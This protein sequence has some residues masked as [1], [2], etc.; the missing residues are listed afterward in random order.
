MLSQTTNRALMHLLDENRHFELNGRGTTN[1]CPMA[2]YALAAMGASDARL[3]EFFNGW[4]ERHAIA[5]GQGAIAATR[6]NYAHLM[7]NMPAFGGLRDCFETWIN[8]VG[9]TPIVSEV[10]QAISFAPAS[11]A[12]HALIRLAY[13]LEAGHAGEIA[14]GLAAMVCGHL[15]IE[16]ERGNRAPAASV[17]DGLAMLSRQVAG[18][19]IT[20]NSITSRLRMVAADPLFQSALPA[21]PAGLGLLDE[22]ALAALA[23][24]RQSGNF[25]ALHMVTGL[26]A[27]RVL[28]ERLPPEFARQR[29]P[30]LWAAF[31]AAY[32]SFG[33]PSL[34]VYA[35][36][37]TA[38]GA[39][40]WDL[41]LA[42]ALQSN[43]DHDIKFTYTCQREF[44][45]RH[46]PAYFSAA[47]Q[48]LGMTQL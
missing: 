44:L 13:G 36:D 7:G 16:I 26:H 29:A 45:Y 1:H 22:M 18:L 21:A 25:T 10:V 12:F 17:S 46:A 41:I 19:H 9:A 28:F 2:L 42:R 32:V 35:D 48:R 47:T 3:E 23:L 31:C 34:A 20:G 5:M 40:A 8:E 4:Q 39:F 43:D 30:E 24:Y 38:P 33:A 37:A 11:G 27:A 6:H 15:S 14:A